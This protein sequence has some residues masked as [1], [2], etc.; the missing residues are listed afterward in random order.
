MLRIENYDRLEDGGPIAF[1]L[2]RALCQAGRNSA[3][4]WVLPD[5]TRH[6]SGHHFTVTFRDG[7]HWLEDV[8]TNGT[9]LQGQRYRLDGPHRMQAGDRLQVGHY[10]IS[11]S[12]AVHAATPLAPP[13]P[14]QPIA[15]GAASWPADD[16]PWAVGG[17]L[18]PVDPFPA[19]PGARRDD[20]AD[21]FIAPPSFAAPGPAPDPAPP[22]DP[23][24][25][26][27]L[28]AAPRPDPSAL[29]VPEAPRPVAPVAAPAEPAAPAPT[30]TAPAPDP[31]AV[32]AA[33]C[34][35]AGLDPSAYGDADA[36]ALARM[37]GAA[38]RATTIET[39]DHLRARAAFKEG[40]RHHVERTMAGMAGNPLKTAP[41]PDR[42][43]EELFFRP[44]AGAAS[45]ADAMGAAARDLRLHHAALIAALQPALGAVLHDLAPEQVEKGASGGLLS[46]SKKSKA[47]DAFVERWD[48]KAA[49]HEN[50]MLDEF[51]S[52]FAQAY[53]DALKSN[54]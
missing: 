36:L 43:L 25:L 22:P 20:F 13:T 5:P 9:F 7:A 12:D 23:S 32:V 51:F 54:D 11:V 40:T 31:P 44:R 48:S 33:F 34:E 15:G 46:G 16:D 30:P 49:R 52:H 3:M 42:A 38:L 41:H 47:W 2:T 17:A 18:E 8:S 10:I 21:E 37:A 1:K 24:G 39:M 45:G 14:A 50:G 35:G 19:E 29:P 26:R 28:T 53:A 27:P 6:I 4:D